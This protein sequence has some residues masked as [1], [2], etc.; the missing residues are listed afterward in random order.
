MAMPIVLRGSAVID[1]KTVVHDAMPRDQYMPRAIDPGMFTDDSY[2]K[3][4]R[5]WQ[6]LPLAVVTRAEPFALSSE[7]A[8]VALSPGGQAVVT[9]HVQRAS[10][11]TAAV[12]LEFRGLPAKVTA[13]PAAIPSG[14]SEV[15]VT[16]SAAADAPATVRNLIIQGRLDKAV[17]VAPAVSVSVKR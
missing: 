16:L 8:E 3:P 17:Q 10:G 7:P 12:A 2:R 4:Y 9:V 1:G 15:R 14:A 6:L 13:A 11:A 5:A